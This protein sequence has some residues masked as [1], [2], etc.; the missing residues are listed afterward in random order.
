MDQGRTI[1]FPETN[2]QDCY[3]EVKDFKRNVVNFSDTLHLSPLEMGRQGERGE[4]KE[5][6]GKT[7]RTS[8]RQREQALHLSTAT[9][10]CTN[11]RTL[12]L[13]AASWVPRRLDG[14]AHTQW[15]PGAVMS[16]VSGTRKL[17]HGHGNHEGLAPT[18][19][20]GVLIELGGR[21][22]DASLHLPC[23]KPSPWMKALVLS[24]RGLE[25][26]YTDGTFLHIGVLHT[27]KFRCLYRDVL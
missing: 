20:F 9:Q 12:R 13:A 27:I 17:H 18:A 4:Y 6:K 16:A 15:L 1:A 8:R 5:T 14:G 23:P 26:M 3:E 11:T 25:V 21:S 24:C 7:L 19:V 2:E 10:H 22:F